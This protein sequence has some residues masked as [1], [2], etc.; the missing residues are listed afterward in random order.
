M[1][2]M[3]IISRRELETLPIWEFEKPMKEKFIALKVITGYQFDNTKLLIKSGRDWFSLSIYRES[4]I[5][6]HSIK[7]KELQKAFGTRVDLNKVYTIT[8]W[9]YRGMEG[10]YV[11]EIVIESYDKPIPSTVVRDVEDT[12]ELYSQ[13]K[14]T[15]A[16]CGRIIER[17]EIAGHFFAGVYC[18]PCWLGRR[19]EHKGEGGRQA[20]EARETY[21]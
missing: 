10:L 11:G 15:C 3:I 7:H 6:H 19:G 17:S 18:D 13:G 14:I 16:D 12:M 2:G 5:G 4:G 21:E 20:V 9:D 1:E 8:L